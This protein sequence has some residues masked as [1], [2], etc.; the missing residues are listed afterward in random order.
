VERVIKQSGQLAGEGSQV[1]PRLSVVVPTDT[2]DTI[3]R[4][5]RRLSALTI[6]GQVELVVVCPDERDLGAIDVG[7]LYSVKIVE[8]VLLPLGDARAAGVRAA[9]ASIVVIGETHA[10]PTEGWADALVRAHDE[11]WAIVVPA[12][13]NGN[14]SGGV[15]SW[16]SFLIDYGRWAPGGAAG[17]TSDPPV[18]NAAFKRDLLLPFGERLGVLLDPGSTLPVE[19]EASGR[20]AYYEP[21][22]QIEHLNL[23]RWGPWLHE[24][25]LGG[26]MLAGARRARWSRRRT[27]VYAIGAPLIP[28]VLV[29]RTR[30]IG[31]GAS[32]APAPGRTRAAIVV[33]CVA[34]AVGEGVGYVTGVGS[35]ELPMLEYELHKARYA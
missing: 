1:T 10:F 13:V 17:E 23:A 8:H 16:S 29:Y 9:D 15:T 24:R 6:A 3:R 30:A 25:F 20:R 31:R 21:H 26:R 35:A 4:L 27:L 28:F 19:L 33:A 7:A 5:I 2:F 14:P 18:Y 32:A 11:P 34:W 12:V 22:A